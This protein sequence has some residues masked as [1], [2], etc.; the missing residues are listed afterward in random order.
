MGGLRFRVIW[1]TSHLDE[2]KEIVR[3]V[4]ISNCVDLVGGIRSVDVPVKNVIY[5]TDHGLE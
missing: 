5:K 4:L 1:V 2:L 3:L